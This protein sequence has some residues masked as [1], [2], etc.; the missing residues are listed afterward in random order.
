[1][2][3]IVTTFITSI[4]VVCTFAFGIVFSPL[5]AKMLHAHGP[6]FV[7]CLLGGCILIAALVV[8]AR[9]RIEKLL[10]GE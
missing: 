4:M 8:L 7:F 9:S 2:K 6:K 3:K 5:T 10:N 1:M